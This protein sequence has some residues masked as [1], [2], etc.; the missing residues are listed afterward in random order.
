VI[1]FLQPR[2][3]PELNNAGASWILKNCADVSAAPNG[4]GY[5]DAE[6]VGEGV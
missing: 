5:S 3:P 6:V 1:A 2:P 4:D